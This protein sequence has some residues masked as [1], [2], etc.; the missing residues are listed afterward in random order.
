MTI[1]VKNLLTIL[2]PTWI[3][4]KK[5]FTIYKDVLFFIGLSSV[6]ILQDV[7]IWNDFINELDKSSLYTINNQ[8]N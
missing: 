8:D 5:Y 1:E 3:F 2:S 6:E 4:T 7:K